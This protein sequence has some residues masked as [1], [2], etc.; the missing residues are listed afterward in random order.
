MGRGNSGRSKRSGPAANAGGENN[1]P[2][3][4]RKLIDRANAAGTVVDYGTSTAN[5]YKRDTDEIRQMDMPEDEKKKAIKDLHALT[6]K[7]LEAESR[8]RSPYSMGEGPARANVKQMR[9]R[10]DQAVQARQNTRSFMEN[11]REEQKKKKK[12]AA[13]D[14]RVQA[15][16][17]A[18]ASGALSVTIDG[19]TWVRKSKRS[20]T[21]T[22]Q[23]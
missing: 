20:K 13:N 14:R 10:A 5:Q 8:S 3:L 6:T 19:Q 9:Q 21:F 17:D 2:E 12:T 11:L 15:L 16:R 1:T 4:D 23:R 7:Q 22:L 18:M